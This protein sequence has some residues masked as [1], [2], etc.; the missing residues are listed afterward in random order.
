MCGM[1][2]AIRVR[3]EARGDILAGD[4]GG[5]QRILCVQE[6]DDA[7][8]R[9]AGRQQHDRDSF[10]AHEDIKGGR[11]DK[12]PHQTERRAEGHGKQRNKRKGESEHSSHGKE[13]AAGRRKIKSERGIKRSPG[14]SPGIL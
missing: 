3:N 11:E 14:D 13:E 12:T 2:E 6:G 5:K 1:Y 10:Q 8:H 4:A 9:C 7:K